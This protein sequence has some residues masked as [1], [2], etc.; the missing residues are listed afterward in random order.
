MGKYCHSF[1]RMPTETRIVA[2]GPDDRTVRTAEGLVLQAPANWVLVPP[3]DAALTRRV[4]AAG[5]TWTV[6]E[7]KGRKTFSL[8]VW[9]LVEHV[10]AIRAEL[11][12]ERCTDAYAKRRTADAARR[13]KKQAVYVEDF[14][15]AVRQFLAFA[16]LHAELA[17]RLALAVT[18]HATPVGSGTVARTQRI[19]IEQRAESAVIAWLRHQTTGYDN[20]KIPRVKGK[21]REVRRMLAEQSRKLLA[22][23]RAGEAIP[24]ENCLLRQALD[25]VTPG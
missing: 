20:M 14:A 13:D 9:A 3:G 2:P 4:K 7:K 21:R 16:P 25:N 8:G 10:D 15:G 12:A 24:A 19:P 1:S 6:Q 5:P 11:A 22:K 17:Q 23:Y 18:R